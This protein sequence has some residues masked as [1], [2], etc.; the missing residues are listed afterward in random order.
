MD[1]QWK[2]Y[3]YRMQ[4]L[5]KDLAGHDS[6]FNE[7]GARNDT[8]SAKLRT[9]ERQLEDLKFDNSR[10]YNEVASLRSNEHPS[11][12]ERNVHF[13]TDQ[14]PDSYRSGQ[15]TDRERHGN[16]RDDWNRRGEPQM[17]KDLD[18]IEMHEG[19]FKPYASNYYQD[20]LKHRQPVRISS[21]SIHMHFTLAS[22]TYNNLS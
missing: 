7:F 13:R 17:R 8:H 19:N 9:L 18:R 4:S 14:P 15:T 20:H 5:E 1:P 3:H 6:R 11:E 2:T 12:Q 16:D 10:L 22:S 21:C